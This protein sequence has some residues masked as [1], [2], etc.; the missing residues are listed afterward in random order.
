MRPLFR[1]FIY[2]MTY[3]FRPS[4]QQQIFIRINQ[5]KPIRLQP[6]IISQSDEISCILFFILNR[7]SS[8]YS[9]ALILMVRLMEPANSLHSCT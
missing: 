4:S 5:H 7:S 9:R 8:N 3:D 2:S 6:S 1:F